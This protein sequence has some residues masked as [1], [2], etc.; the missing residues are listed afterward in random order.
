[1]ATLTSMNSRVAL[2]GVAAYLP[3]GQRSSAEVESL[4][5]AS[6]P[7]LRVPRG[8]VELMTGIRCRRVAADD[9]NAS[10]LAAAAGR[11]VLDKTGIDPS[12]VDLLI[13]ASVSQDLVEPATANIVQEKV[14]THGPVFDLKNACNS[15]LNALQVAEALIQNGTYRTILV[16]VG[17]LPSR[18][19]KWSLRDRQDL[20]LSFPGYTLGD[21]GAAAVLQ[22]SENGRGIYYRSFK[23]ASRFWDLGVIPGG[24][25]M[26]PRG[27]EWTY[28]QGDGSLLK[29][30]FFEVGP[31]I[32]QD[33]LAATGTTCADY[34][35]V[36]VHQVSMPFIRTFLDMSGVP[37]EKIVVTL[38]ELGNMGAAS[39]PVAFAVAEERGEIHRG[40]RLM[41]IGL[42]GGIS[43]GVMLMEY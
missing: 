19:I 39:L 12:D 8:I 38:P 5:V 10:D 1:V 42:A 3:P 33:A 28:I 16:T 20:R 21:A 7:Q 22:P 34:Q 36:L 32:L 25:S 18:C 17:E 30:A 29:D 24:G 31:A 40:D 23:T 4:I 13:Y 11:R 6:S 27:D 9:V 41:W 43:M 2:T 14:G 35:R 37:Q 26:H 15:F